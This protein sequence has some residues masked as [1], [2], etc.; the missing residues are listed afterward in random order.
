[1]SE[2]VGQTTREVLDAWCKAKTKTF[3]YQLERGVDGG[4]LHWSIWFA[5][6]RKERKSW[7]LTTGGW[8]RMLEELKGMPVFYLEQSL[9][10]KGKDYSTKEAT[11]VAGP[12][13]DGAEEV[14][15][16]DGDDLAC[17][18]EPY[19]WQKWV[20]EHIATKPDDRSV[21][22]IYDAEGCKGKSKLTKY[23][24]W[25][26]LAKVINVD[27]AARLSSAI[28]KA[29]KERCYVIDIPRT[30]CKDKSLSSVVNVMEN[31]KNGVVVDN[32]Y[33]ADNNLLMAPPHVMVFANYP[34]PRETMSGD[35]WKVFRITM[36]RELAADPG[37]VQA[38]LAI[39]DV[40]SWD[41]E[42]ACRRGVRSYK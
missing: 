27:S 3:C 2:E 36:D 25:K 22:W 5:L 34:P 35:R 39:E 15:D 9:S 23:L 8:R 21:Y 11:R 38:P 10:G 16:Y 14:D 30:I 12:W 1:M 28:V 42:G 40:R 33:G 13:G 4:L 18:G 32:M 19:P 26:K 37:P 20:L 17:M 7:I 24:I 6:K 29:G 31:L 41:D